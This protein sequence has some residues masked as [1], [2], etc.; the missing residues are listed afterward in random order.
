MKSQDIFL[1]LKL[2]SLEQSLKA[3]AEPA[4]IIPMFPSPPAPER[5]QDWEGDPADLLEELP[6]VESQTSD[7]DHYSVRSLADATG[8]S[9]SEVSNILCRCYANGLAKLQRSGTPSTNRK[10]L[11]EFLVYGL[12]Y[13]FPVKMLGL[14]RGIATGLTAPVFGGELRA[15]SEHT[16]VW[17]DP[18][19]ATSGPS[20]EPLY[21]T[22]PHAVRKDQLLYVFLALADSIRLGLPR[23]RNLAVRKLHELLQN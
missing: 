2:V 9:K 10:G 7:P 21:K 18:K 8:I 16:P 14:T 1:L 12:K 22:V 11:E 4:K 19:G 5:W 20:V 3:K 15:A 13:V 17:A 23:E 6:P